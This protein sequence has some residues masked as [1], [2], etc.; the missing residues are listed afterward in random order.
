MKGQHKMDISNLIVLIISCLL[1]VGTIVVFTLDNKVSPCKHKYDNSVIITEASEFETGESKMHCEKCGHEITQRINAT[2]NMPQLYLDGL[3][4]GISKNSDCMLRA[5]YYEGDTSTE[6]YAAIKYQGHTSINFE[7]K[8]YTIKFYEEN[9]RSSK[10]KISV[11]G[12]EP[13]HKYCLKANYIDF[14]GAR[15]VVSSNI[16]SDVVASRQQLNSSIS[17]LEFYGGIDGFPVAL[18]INGEYQG[19]Y[20]FNIP[21]DEDTYNI[22]DDKNEAMFVINSG[23]SK[24]A[25]FKAELLEEDKGS[26]FDLEY[27]YMEDEGW[28]YERLNDLLK[29]VKGAD[30]HNFR[31]HVGEYLDVDAAIDYLITTYVLGLTDNFSKNMILLTYDGKQWIPNMYD[32]DTAFGLAFDGTLFEKLD[33]C[34]P[35]ISKSGQISSGTENLL[36]DKLLTAYPEKFKARY[37]ELRRNILNNENI[38]ARYKTFID[39]IPA[40]CYQKEV[41]LYPNSPW[42]KIDHIQQMTEFLTERVKLLDSVINEFGK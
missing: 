21:K 17:N 33:F 6:A 15:N 19:L 20:T 27:S 1:V 41:L 2:I 31:A 4:D 16:W 22:A 42:N 3:L 7:K 9:S 28:P 5:V 40:N 14:S 23:F 26:I 36:W 35:S 10:Y 39:N 25:N 38:I 29:F 12:W 8:N 32:L 24:S 34:L 13:K 11:N 37:F 30:A 18:F